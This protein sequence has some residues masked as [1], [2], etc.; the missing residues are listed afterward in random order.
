[1]KID[2]LL[3]GTLAIVLI[4][5]FASPTFA[6]DSGIA[7]I[8]DA[9]NTEVTDLNSPFGADPMDIVYE[10][11]VPIGTGDSLFLHI[12]SVADDFVLVNPTSITDVHFVLVERDDN[13]PTTFDGN[14]QYAILG[15]NEGPDPNN[16][17]G[18][19][20][21]IK[22]ETED[23]GPGSLN[24][25]PRILV[26]FDLESPV[27]LDAGVTYWLWLHAGDGFAATESLGWELISGPST[28]G[29][30]ARFY[31]GGDFTRTP[32]VACIADTWFQLTHKQDMVGGESLPIDSTA[33]LLAG[34]QS[35]AIWMLPVIAGAA[36]A[37]FGT[38][39]YTTRRN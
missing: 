12:H 25:R 5:G 28:I 21:A 34:L 26:W 2:K 31:S 39:Y 1:L 36:V 14:I 22:L 4:A 35:S 38:L 32:T 15:D 29:D 8:E 13:I 24:D 9:P 20:N 33:L 23:L 19:G 30:C 16:V 3:A 11:G 7:Q 37:A 10:N 18:S 6:V 27:P 17:L